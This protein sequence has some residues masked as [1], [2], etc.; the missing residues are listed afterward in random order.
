MKTK[1]NLGKLKEQATGNLMLRGIRWISKRKTPKDHM[2]NIINVYVPTSDQVEKDEKAMWEVYEAVQKLI[3]TF[4]NI[5]A[6]I[7]LIA[8]YFKKD[9]KE[10][11][12]EGGAHSSLFKR[13]SE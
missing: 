3:K 9:Q 4:Q 2:I 13:Y 10:T 5:L 6:S 11:C 1:A 7:I 8:V 12:G